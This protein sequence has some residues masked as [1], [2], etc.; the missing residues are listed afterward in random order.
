M[1]SEGEVLG[2]LVAANKPGGFTDG[3]VQLL[4]IFAGP[5]ATFLRS[6]QIFTAQRRHASRL[7]RLSALVGDMA[8]V[9]GPAPLLDLAVRRIQKDLGYDARLLPRARRTGDGAW[10]CSREAGASSGH[11]APDAEALRWALRLSAPL[12]ASRTDLA[13]ELA[14]PVRAG[15]QALGVLACARRRRRPSRR[16]R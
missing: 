3:D 8:A 15:D 6:R 16:R 1:F 4:S 12:E 5:A 10:S 2:L 9:A 7:E 14:V 13:S 11:A